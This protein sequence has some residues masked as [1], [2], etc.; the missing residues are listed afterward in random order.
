LTRLARRWLR[1][2]VGFERFVKIQRAAGTSGLSATWR[3][4]W[5]CEGVILKGIKIDTGD[6]A[7][8]PF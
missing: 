2:G 6:P 4:R 7:P 3:R 8:N 5:Q 1:R